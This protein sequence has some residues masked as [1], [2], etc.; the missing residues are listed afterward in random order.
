LIA[1]GVFAH[2]EVRR[3]AGFRLGLTLA[4]A[5]GRNDFG[6]A[7]YDIGDLKAHASP[8]GLAFATSVNGNEATGH[9]ELGDV[10]ILPNDICSE[11][12]LI[13]TG[14]TFLIGGPDGVFEFFNLHAIY[15]AEPGKKYERG[16]V[17]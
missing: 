16:T 1:F 12:G 13:K 5:P 2:G 4:L 14:S 11:D 8:S 6:G 10:R 3:L 9:R 7:G 15:D 17:N